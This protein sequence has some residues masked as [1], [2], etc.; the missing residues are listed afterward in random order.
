MNVRILSRVVLVAVLLVVSATAFAQEAKD[1]EIAA[2]EAT[3]GKYFQAHATGDGAFIREAFHP[4]GKMMWVNKD[5]QLAS[6][7]AEEFA[8]GFSGKAAADEAQRKRQIVSVDRTGEVAI[9]KII[10][11]YPAV[12]FTDYFMLAKTDGQWRII[13]KGYHREAPQTK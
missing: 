13:A 11:D 6:R 9:A 8:A 1:P 3:I 4:E 7:T 12:K 5:A 10:L 2:I